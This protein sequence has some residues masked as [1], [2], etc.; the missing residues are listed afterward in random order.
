MNEKIKQA[1]SNRLRRK[2]LEELIKEKKSTAYTIAKYLNVPEASVSNHLEILKKAD[3]V[4]GPNIDTSTGR[5]KKIYQTS[6]KA[7]QLLRE[8][9][10]EEINK[11]PN[12]IKKLY[13]K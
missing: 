1:L 6:D 2:V 12:S 13:K 11:A 9:W 7:E 5:L 8:F 3:L 10:I 4:K